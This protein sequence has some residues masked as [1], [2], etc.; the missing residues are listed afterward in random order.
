MGI[1]SKK[2][3][4]VRSSFF[5]FEDGLVSTVGLL[6]GI[7]AA[8]VDN[9]AIITTGIVLVAVEA[10]SMGV[11]GFLSEET[12]EEGEHQRR[13]F[14]LSLDSGFALL[15]SYI[16]AGLIPLM[17][18]FLGSST[19]YVYISIISALISLFLLGFVGGK[20]MKTN[21]IKNALRVFALGGLT[22][23]VGI[24]IGNLFPVA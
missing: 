14:K 7:A 23:L 10:L 18:Y 16:V 3:I 13:A 12:V 6:S 15:F 4:V 11:G 21:P 5:G 1:E 2:E 8:G 17:P 24:F 9:K 20:V 22:I 19:V